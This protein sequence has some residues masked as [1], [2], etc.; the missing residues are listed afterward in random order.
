MSLTSLRRS[1]AQWLSPDPDTKTLTEQLMATRQQLADSNTALATATATY[2]TTVAA[3]SQQI[4]DRDATI[5]ADGQ[6]IA[7]LQQELDAWSAQA[8]QNIATEQQ[9]ID[10]LKASTPATSGS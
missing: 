4:K 1:V 9:A 2:G 8:D 3:L 7:G 6:K 10:V 5:A